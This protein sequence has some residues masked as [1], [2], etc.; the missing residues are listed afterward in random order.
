MIKKMIQWYEKYASKNK[1]LLNYY[2]KKYDK[3]IENEINLVGITQEDNVLFIGSGAIPFTPILMALKTKAS[4]TAIDSDHKAIK[5]AK[6]VVKKYGLSHLITIKHQDGQTLKNHAYSIVVLALQV[7]PLRIIVSNIMQPDTKIVIRQ[8]FEHY[9]H[10]YDC[11]DDSF[12][13]IK[14]VN[15]PMKY[16]GTSMW[17][18]K[19]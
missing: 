12:K 8:P 15:Q 5:T 17:V 19:L 3:I 13:I 9:K 1:L 10:L 6:K 2:I 16:F 7:T 11:I 4:V 14:Q 18:E